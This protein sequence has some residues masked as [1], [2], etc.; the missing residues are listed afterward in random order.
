MC[1]STSWCVYCMQRRKRTPDCR[2]LLYMRFCAN[3]DHHI[4]PPAG[5]T[6]KNE[7]FFYSLSLS[8]SAP[9]SKFCTMSAGT[10]QHPSPP[11]HSHPT[12]PEYW[13]GARLPFVTLTGGIEDD[14][15]IN[16]LEFCLSNTAHPLH[17]ITGNV[18]AS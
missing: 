16:V 14:G 2:Y 8:L 1:V 11:L 17:Q 3:Q 15:G 7:G 10:H 12:L 13:R 18:W 6:K 4:C 9:F 5:Q